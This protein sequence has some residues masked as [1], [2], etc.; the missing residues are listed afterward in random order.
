MPVS[1]GDPVELCL[2]WASRIGKVV[3]TFHCCVL[4]FPDDA[5]VELRIE[6]LVRI[7]PSNG[8][9]DGPVSSPTIADEINAF[10]ASPIVV[11]TAVANGAPMYVISPIPAER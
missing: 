5:H 1:V 3:G 2:A 6:H 10:I 7:V 11:P 4:G 9:L 8:D